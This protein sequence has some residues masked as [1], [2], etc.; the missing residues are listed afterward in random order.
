MPSSTRD[1]IHVSVRLFSILRHRDGKI[2]DRLELDLPPDSRASDVL[3]RLNI[4]DDVSP[5]LSIN[6]R[7]VKKDAPLSDGDTLAIV[8]AIAGG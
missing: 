2:V 4:A 7:L 6:N 1:T 3:H 5:A 8:P